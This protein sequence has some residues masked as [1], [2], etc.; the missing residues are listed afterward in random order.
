ML[1]PQQSSLVL[2]ALAL[3][4]GV[5]A[6][7]PP[8]ATTRTTSSISNVVSSLSPRTVDIPVSRLFMAEGDDEAGD[9]AAEA[10]AEDG[11]EGEDDEEEKEPE[12]DP[13]VTA[14]KKEIA[15]LE[16]T[17]KSKKSTLSYTLDQA[18]EYTKAGYARK[19]AEMEN[20]RRIRSVRDKK[21]HTN[22]CLFDVR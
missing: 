8:L 17:L 20:M 1:Q 16:T 19:V 18:E 9:D 12:E 3:L 11:D 6:F 10:S 15:E 2:A 22:V 21:R 13:E 5:D 4:A 7:A 14:I